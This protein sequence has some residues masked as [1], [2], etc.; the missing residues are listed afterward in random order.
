[1]HLHLSFPL[2][3]S[4][5]SL[6]LCEVGVV[7]KC[8]GVC[9]GLLLAHCVESVLCCSPAY[10]AGPGVHRVPQ[11]CVDDARGTTLGRTILLHAADAGDGQSGQSF[12]ITWWDLLI[13]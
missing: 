12:R 1:M 13:N 8:G 3:L 6:C 2:S 11:G 4:L 7:C 5:C 9:H 10:R